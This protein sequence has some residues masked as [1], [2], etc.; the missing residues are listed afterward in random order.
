MADPPAE[1]EHRFGGYQGPRQL[2]WCLEPRCMEVR[3]GDYRGV[4]RRLTVDETF[5]L[6]EHMMYATAIGQAMTIVHGHDRGLQRAREVLG[7]V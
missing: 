3:V 5:G 7:Y 1:H 2:G 4:W 6:V